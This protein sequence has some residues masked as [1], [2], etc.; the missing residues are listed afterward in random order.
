MGRKRSIV[1]ERFF[2]FVLGKYFSWSKSNFACEKPK[3][4]FGEPW[5][6]ETSFGKSLSIFA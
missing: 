3:T 1:L 6:T 2:T 4:Y 5:P